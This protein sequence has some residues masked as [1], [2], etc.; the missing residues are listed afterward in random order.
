MPKIAPEPAADGAEVAP[1]KK[2]GK[3]KAKKATWTEA[4]D[5]ATGSLYYTNNKTGEVAWTKPDGSNND[6]HIEAAARAYDPTT[7]E[8]FFVELV[9]AAAASSRRAQQAAFTAHRPTPVSTLLGDNGKKM[10][11]P[12]IHPI[13]PLVRVSVLKNAEPPRAKV[14]VSC[15]DPAD[16]ASHYWQP[17]LCF[18]A[19]AD[20]MPWTLP[21][22]IE[23]RREPT[24]HRL[25]L[26]AQNPQARDIS[27]WTV[28]SPVPKGF[29]AFPE[30]VPG[31]SPFAL[32]WSSGPDR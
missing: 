24:C 19:F 31:S 2:K 30:P 3:K 15:G 13:A 16:E 26:Q 28:D 5:D 17:S 10:V 1:K 25:R 23:A 8:S 4:V 14:V 32:D 27:K 12:N 7:G 22:T 11:F 20:T 9:G 18:Y 29:F 21:Y 6:P